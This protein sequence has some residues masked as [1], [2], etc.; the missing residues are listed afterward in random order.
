MTRANDLNNTSY[1]GSY[2]SSSMHV[3][4]YTMATTQN[5][6]YTPNAAVE[7]HRVGNTSINRS[8]S[9]V[10]AVIPNIA[11]TISS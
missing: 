7:C 4:Y 5:Y 2:F 8:Y 10:E 3:C 6:T 9:E 11:S 1:I